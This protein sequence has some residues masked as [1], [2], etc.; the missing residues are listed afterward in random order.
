MIVRR[1]VRPSTALRMMAHHD[2]HAGRLL[3]SGS[4]PERR[5]R[6]GIR[7]SCPEK[8][9]AKNTIIGSLRKSCPAIAAGRLQSDA[10]LRKRD[11]CQ[12]RAN[13]DSRLRGNDGRCSYGLCNRPAGRR[14]SC[15][16]TCM[17]GCALLK[18]GHRGQARQGEARRWAANMVCPLEERVNVA[19]IIPL[20]RFTWDCNGV[21]N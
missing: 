7:L 16:K 18:S 3:G 17:L 8:Y 19:T 10:I 5:V 14:R 4:G 12:P 20:Q 11:A 13:L 21:P 9:H 15:F 1:V 6:P 2:D